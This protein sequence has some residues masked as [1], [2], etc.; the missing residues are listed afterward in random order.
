MDFS[1][2]FISNLTPIFFRAFGFLTLLPF[3]FSIVKFGTRMSL[4]LFIALFFSANLPMAHSGSTYFVFFEFLI[5]ALLA[6]PAALFVNLVEAWG[7]LFD[8][9]RGQSISQAYDPITQV[10]GSQFSMLLRYLIWA[11]LLY[12]GFMEQGIVALWDSFKQIPAGSWGITN[13]SNNSVHLLEMIGKLVSGLFLTFLPFGL[14]F[15]LVEV[16]V[17]FLSKLVPKISL[18]GESFLCKTIVGFFLLFALSRFEL[19]ASLLRITAPP[20]NFFTEG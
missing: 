13:F 20:L 9:A 14:A 5:G 8:T 10:H 2:A 18:F 6:L 11:S 12:L 19:G 3:G 1:E 17:G 4:A 7:S 15:L 16:A